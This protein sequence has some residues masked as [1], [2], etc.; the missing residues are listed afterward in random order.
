MTSETADAAA[1]EPAP[2]AAPDVYQLL[3]AE[4]ALFH[5]G[6]RTQST[7]LL[8][9]FL[10]SVWRLDPDVASDAICDGGGDKGI[11]A[12]DVDDDA[13]EIV[14][15][16]AKHR[17]TANL[18]QGDN[19]L[20]SFIG[21]ATY[22]DNAE[23]IDAL[24]ASKPNDEVVKLIERLD[25]RAKV[26]SGNYTVRLVF[27]TNALLDA[28]GA[29]YVAARANQVPPLEV[30]DRHRLAGV[31][32]RTAV[33]RVSEADV[34]LTTA[35]PPIVV[36]LEDEV[37]MAI[38]LVSSPELVRL[39]GIDD[40][41]IFELN[42]RLGLGKTAINKQLAATIRDKSQ[43]KLFST[44][45][46]GMTL[47]TN[48]FEVDGCDLKLS[49]VGVVNGCQSL[50]ALYDNR[51]SLTPDLQ[52]LVRIVEL[53]TQDGLVDRITER[54]NNQNAVTIR[55]Q[56]S[57]DKIQRDL[58]TQLREAYPGELELAIRSGEKLDGETI[59]NGFLAQM[60]LATYLDEP[61]S[62]V[63]KVRLFAQDYYRIFNK[64]LDAH[65]IVFLYELDQALQKARSKLNAELVAAFSSVRFTL[66]YLVVRLIRLTPEGL[67][68]VD[69]P[70]ALLQS[71][72]DAVAA[73]LEEL[74]VE[75][76][77][78]TNFFIDTKE[79]EAKD[80]GKTFDAKVAFKS[81]TS[82]LD[83]ARDAERFANLAMR[84]QA[85]YGFHLNP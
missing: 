66:A 13:R 37:R 77:T 17:T 48:R 59:D 60:V 55:D 3:A 84:R 40:L 43:H 58:Q 63:R 26:A 76:V 75:A 51:T 45:H 28:A 38:G 83:I 79:Q 41:T 10:E 24:L 16:Q 44:Y 62:A 69:A 6:N 81:R 27:V 61:W 35:T 39:P 80:E 36:E 19:D 5:V 82:V 50:L 71:D 54:T 32:A 12:I 21:V 47:L 46:N 18:K 56:R 85:D 67:A 34:A 22:F 20:K 4:T 11:D 57:T 72:R 52:V 68:F 78:S 42:V 73:V 65:R 8:A 1:A 53:G 25:V 31:A 33:L 29:D 49:G 9:W 15:F 14:V 64:D 74:A 7:A 70:A 30:W 2:A 23:G